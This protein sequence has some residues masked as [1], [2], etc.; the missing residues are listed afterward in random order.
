MDAFLRAQRRS[1]G[2]LINLLHEASSRGAAIEDEIETAVVLGV[3]ESRER[4]ANGRGAVVGP[5]SQCPEVLVA[6]LRRGEN[7]NENGIGRE[8]SG[9]DMQSGATTAWQE[10]DL[11]HSSDG[12]SSWFTTSTPSCASIACLSSIAIDIEGDNI[13]MWQRR[14][15]ART[16]GD[17]IFAICARRTRALLTAITITSCICCC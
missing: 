13:F 4:S 8:G 11:S 15:T 14:E 16:T 2:S 5:C 7:S 12:S 3:V 17:R 10:G 6:R 1:R 9:F